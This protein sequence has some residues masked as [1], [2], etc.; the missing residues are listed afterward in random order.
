MCKEDDQVIGITGTITNWFVTQ[1]DPYRPPETQGIHVAG[2]IH[3]DAKKRWEDGHPMVTTRVVKIAG[4]II[5]TR[6][7]SRYKLG[8]PKQDYVDWCKE[9]GIEPP[10]EDEPIRMKTSE[11]E[12]DEP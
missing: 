7:G 9:N 12:V 10:T 5:T 3:G 11:K 4:R 1:L 2:E 6:S 8:K